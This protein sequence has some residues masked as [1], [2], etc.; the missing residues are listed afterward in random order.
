MVRVDLVRE[1]I[2]R[3]R[4]TLAMLARILPPE[5]SSLLERDA[6]DLVAFRVYLVVQESVDIAAHLIADEGWGP[7]PSLRDH[8]AVLQQRGVIDA[9]LAGELSS[10]VKV[11]NVIAHGYAEVDVAK[12]HAAG[13]ELGPIAERYCAR[14]LTWAETRASEG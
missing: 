3:L 10:S 11:R 7:A 8:F 2:R 12:L 4:G 1:K 9:A 6:I 14:V 5:A 13:V